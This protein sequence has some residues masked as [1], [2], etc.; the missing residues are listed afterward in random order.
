MTVMRFIF[1]ML[2]VDRLDRFISYRNL[3][4]FRKYY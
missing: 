2:N 4:V 3:I 1:R